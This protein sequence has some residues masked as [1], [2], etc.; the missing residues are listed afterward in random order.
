MTDNQFFDDYFA[1]YRRALFE[2]DVRRQLSAFRDLCA[3][4]LNSAMAS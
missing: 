1:R 4:K 2:T 3:W